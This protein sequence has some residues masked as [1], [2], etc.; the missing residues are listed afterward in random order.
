V[1]PGAYTVTESSVASFTLISIICVDPDGQTTTNLVT[2]T[3]NIDLDAGEV[4][5]CI[6][7]NEKQVQPPPPELIKLTVVKKLKQQD[8]TL[9]VLQGAQVIVTDKTTGQQ[10]ASGTTGAD[11][12][13]MTNLPKGTYI[14]KVIPSQGPNGCQFVPVIDTAEIILSSPKIVQFINTLVC[15]QP[16]VA[17]IIVVKFLD[18][19]MIGVKDPADVPLP[20]VKINLLDILGNLKASGI[21]DANGVVIFDVIASS[22]TQ[23]QITEPSQ[24]LSGNCKIVGTTPILP[25][26]ITVSGGQTK[27]VEILNELEC[28]KAKLTVIKFEDLDGDGIRD[29]T[30]TL[31]P[32]FEGFVIQ[33]FD[34]FGKLVAQGTTNKISPLV[35][36]LVPSKYIVKEV[37]PTP[38]FDCSFIQTFP[39]SATGFQHVV[40]LQEPGD[41][42]KFG[43]KLKCLPPTQP[44]ATVQV[45]KIR[46]TNENNHIDC[47]PLVTPPSSVFCETLPEAQA[48]PPTIIEPGLQSWTIQVFDSSG[49][50][51]ASKVTDLTGHVSFSLVPGTYTF[52]EVN[53]PLPTTCPPDPQ[54]QKP[55]I[56]VQWKQIFPTPNPDHTINVVAGDHRILLFGN[57]LE[58]EVLA[59]IKVE[60]LVNGL[61]GDG[62]IAQHPVTIQVFDQ[63]GTKLI[64]SA[65]T[66]IE[67]NN[68]AFATFF[69]RAGTYV[70]R[71]ALPSTVPDNCIA[72]H[73]ELINVEPQPQPFNAAPGEVIIT[74][75]PGEEKLDEIKFNNKL[76]CP[77]VGK[78]NV[79]KFNDKDGDGIRDMVPFVEPGVA[80]FLIKVYHPN[81]LTTPIAKALT[82]SNGVAMFILE[83][84]PLGQQYVIR[85]D[86]FG[87]IPPD[88]ASGKWVQ[89]FPGAASNFEHK[90]TIPDRNPSGP[91]NIVSKEFGNQL[92]CFV[93]P[94]KLVV[95]K[96]HDD[97]QDGFENNSESGLPGF[98]IKVLNSQ[99][100]PAL[101]ASGL[102]LE[103][104][105]DSSGTVMF[106]LQPGQYIVYEFFRVVQPGEC[107]GGKWI[108][109]SPGPASAQP[110]PKVASMAPNPIVFTILPGETKHIKFGNF[111]GP[112]FND[113]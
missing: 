101:D 106:T 39:G 59:K 32:L 77:N 60:K 20:G 47:K 85:E 67:Q 96:F 99:G 111:L 24:I 69:L 15:P 29:T 56:P 41:E 28:P 84:L 35:F 92:S 112:C 100:T 107:D 43:N 62:L 102:P 90:V 104:I 34:E 73:W 9:T 58:C 94:A 61:P 4:V 81:D 12:S 49:N 54:T 98:K 91:P 18:Q 33:V 68:R 16:T 105:T 31:E 89:T 50:L 37:F 55:R 87:P 46:D 74:L 36:E 11:G 40:V 79:T 22:N 10:V 7:K 44:P 19:G 70:I 53:G 42:I 71:E 14:V 25:L 52:K 21:T 78:L 66:Q 64:A 76:V 83:P 17:K 38:P 1:A 103:G 109:T 2:R 13:F 88:C 95:H 26:T 6:F 72:G 75:S 65:Q 80:G 27:T 30:P 82:D 113:P 8:G 97:N 48:I 5:I 23:F 57:K 108:Q 45:F 63:T 93:P 86:L 110:D 3:A 51:V